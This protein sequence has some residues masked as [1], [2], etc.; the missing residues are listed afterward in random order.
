[1]LIL[2]TVVVLALLALL[3]GWMRSRQ[4]KPA[5]WPDGLGLEKLLRRS[6]RYFDRRRCRVEHYSADGLIL[7]R[8]GRYV[9]LFCFTPDN[10]FTTS[11]VSDLARFL[12][13]GRAVLAV[14]SSAVEP[15][16]AARAREAGVPLFRHWDM[17]EVEAAADQVWRRPVVLAETR[18]PTVWTGTMPEDTSVPAQQDETMQAGRVDPSQR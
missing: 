7:I 5:S 1:M 15:Q 16:I 10:R 18:D 2:G 9:M 4:G 6:V 3:L 17:A 13:Q 11:S 12:H 14:S 8:G